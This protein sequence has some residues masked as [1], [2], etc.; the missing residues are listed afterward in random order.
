MKG[1]EVVKEGAIMFQNGETII[2]VVIAL[3]LLLY[4]HTLPSRPVPLVPALQQSF[5]LTSHVTAA[6]IAYGTF[7]IG[8]GTA[9]LYLFQ[10][11]RI[12]S[13]MPRTEVLD[14]MSYH[15]VVIGFPFMTLVIIL[16][17][18]WADVAW[19]RYWDWDPKETASL[20]TWLIYASYLH[21]RFLHGWRGTRTAILLIIGFAAVLFTFFGNYFFAGLHSY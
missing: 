9:V 13:W 21:A 10:R 5:L 14:A 7:T 8:F 3:G 4:A 17:A 16:G 18:L 12:V 15:T 6:V 1:K 20:V 11:R 19:G 2:G